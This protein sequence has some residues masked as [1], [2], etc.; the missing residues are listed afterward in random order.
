MPSVGFELTILAFEG[1]E[2]AHALGRAATVIGSFLK[3]INI[4]ESI[5][6]GR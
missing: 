1:A 3:Y 5:T 6:F 2:A 4:I